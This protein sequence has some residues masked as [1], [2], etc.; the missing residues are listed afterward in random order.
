M[1]R[2]IMHR[3]LSYAY[4]GS[5]AYEYYAGLCVQAKD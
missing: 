3:H 5:R 4:T 2:R 1:R